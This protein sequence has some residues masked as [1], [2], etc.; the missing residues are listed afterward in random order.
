MPVETHKTLTMVDNNQQVITAKPVSEGYA[1]ICD[2]ADF[3]ACHGRYEPAL[4]V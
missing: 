1:A 4:P 2:G 3:T